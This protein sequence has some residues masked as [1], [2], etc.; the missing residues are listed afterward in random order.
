VEILGH[1]V[2]WSLIFLLCVLLVRRRWAWVRALARDARRLLLLLLAATVIAVNWGVY[3][4]AVNSDHVVEA[5]LGYFINPLVTVLIGIV[6][7]RERLRSAQWAAVGLGIVAVLVLTVGYGRLPWVGLV[8]AM[9]FATYGVVKKVIAMPAVE[10]LTA[11]AALLIVPSLAYLG[12]LESSGEAAFGHE[13]GGHL[14]LM[15][16]LGV[17][18]AVP[19]LLFGAAAPRVPLSTLGLLQYI[20]P[21]MQFALG[22]LVFD[23]HLTRVGI[24]GFALVWLALVVFSVD[25]LRHTSRHPVVVEP[26]T[27]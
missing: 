21:V 10:S 22:V 26:S 6:A 9:S 5:S 7:F 15:M 3:I 20:T 17:I 1:R 23:E 25:G 2:L 11:E 8:L 14:G 16:G 19:L 4:W 13:G 12:W 18:T 27:A 24:A